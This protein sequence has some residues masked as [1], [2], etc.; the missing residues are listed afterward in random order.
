MTSPPPG[1]RY[2]AARN[3]HLA[4]TS[5]AWVGASPFRAGAQILVRVLPASPSYVR[6]DYACSVAVEGNSCP[7]ITHRRT[8]VG[9]GGGLLDVP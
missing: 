8:G 5:N 3:R 9:V 1:L 2:V 4:L 6:G 7:V